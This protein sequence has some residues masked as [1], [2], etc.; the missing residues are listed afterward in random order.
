MKDNEKLVK[1]VTLDYTP[2]I[3]VLMAL[4]HLRTEYETNRANCAGMM[5]I[6]E[7]T[8]W[9]EK[10]VEVATAHEAVSNA[11][12][13]LVAVET[14]ALDARAEDYSRLLEAGLL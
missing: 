8:F 10:L 13:E 3:V 1:V 5:M 14:T 12:L 11:R 4:D 6:N 9:N 2:S 7:M